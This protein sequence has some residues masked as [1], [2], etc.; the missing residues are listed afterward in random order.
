MEN[1]KEISQ[2]FLLNNKKKNTKKKLKNYKSPLKNFLIII[3]LYLKIKIN[4]QKVFLFKN[5][6]IYFVI[7]F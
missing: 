5:L 7:I 4:Y 2:H 6:L 3:Y 1:N